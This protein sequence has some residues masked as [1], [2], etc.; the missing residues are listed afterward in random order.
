MKWNIIDQL[1]K[2]LALDE[3]KNAYQG[4]TFFDLE[5]LEYWH[6]LNVVY[7]NHSNVVHPFMW[8]IIGATMRERPKS[9]ESPGTYVTK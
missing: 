5:L 7:G 9:V 3:W 4:W 8:Y 2:T 6:E 1:C